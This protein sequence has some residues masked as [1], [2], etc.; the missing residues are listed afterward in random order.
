MLH[1]AP[2]IT[3]LVTARERLNLQEEWV[4]SVQGLPF[5]ARV[6]DGR[7]SGTLPAPASDYSAVTLFLQ[8]ARQ[9]VTSFAPTYDEMVEIVRIC[10][11]VEGMPLGL[12]LAAPWL[13][14]LSCREIAQ[15]MQ[16]SLDFLTTPLRNLPERHR[17]LRVVFAQ[18]WQ[19]LSPT[20]QTV[21]QGLSIFRS[22]CTRQAAEQVTGATLPILSSLVDKA[23]LR[24]TASGRYE[25]HELIRQFAEAQVTVALHA[26][27]QAQ[28]RH[29]AYFIMFLETRTTGIKGARQKAILN[30]IRAD[31]DN[32][33]LIWR[34]TVENRDVQAIERSSECLFVFYLYN[35][36]HY[37]GQVAFQQ[38]VAALTTF[39]DALV[40][41]DQTQ[42]LV[43]LDKQEN[44]VGFRLAVQAYF[45]ARTSGR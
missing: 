31:M 34:R 6:E 29:Q 24:R 2:E 12:E 36:G 7:H 35:S 45:L 13:R 43:I 38:A 5:P 41:D 1:H 28:Q 20:E 27:E 14:T 4:Y 18:S 44:L 25:L 26:V 16:Q 10:Q 15:E 22:G 40:D 30:E 33:R 17:S 11:L 42:D 8:R 21:L 39:P 19:R 37:E 23:L 32:I 9:A 3:I